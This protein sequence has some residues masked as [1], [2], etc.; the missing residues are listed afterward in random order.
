M[1]GTIVPLNIPWSYYTSFCVVCPWLYIFSE[2]NL[3]VMF[4]LLCSLFYAYLQNW[5]SSELISKMQSLAE[6]R[7]LEDLTVGPVLTVSGQFFLL[8]LV[9]LCF[10][11]TKLTWTYGELYYLEFHERLLNLLLMCRFSTANINFEVFNVSCMMIGIFLNILFS[12][13]HPGKKEERNY[14]WNPCQYWLVFLQIF[15]LMSST[16]FAA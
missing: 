6:R 12:T 7:K 11:W 13:M 10:N 14:W 2:W 15:Y 3:R 9:I 8:F 4:C 1:N 16:Y 5:V